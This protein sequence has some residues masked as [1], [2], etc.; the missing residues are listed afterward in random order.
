MF[1]ENSS[2]NR[3]ITLSKKEIARV[4]MSLVIIHGSKHE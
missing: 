2:K 1:A 4:I 3:R